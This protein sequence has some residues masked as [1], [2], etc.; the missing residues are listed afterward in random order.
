M[1]QQRQREV[2]AEMEKLCERHGITMYD[3][4]DRYFTENTNH[5]ERVGFI[6]LQLGHAITNLPVEGLRKILPE[7][8]NPEIEWFGKEGDIAYWLGHGV[9]VA[10]LTLPFGLFLL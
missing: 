4:I 8:L 3:V 6:T 1:S 5:L 10:T 2:I 7:K 9:L